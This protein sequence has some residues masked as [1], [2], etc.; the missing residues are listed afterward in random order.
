[1]SANT[2][3]DLG[4]STQQGLSISAINGVGGTPASG[5]LVGGIVDMLHANNYTN[6]V[7][8]GG[9]TSGLLSI[10]VQVSD[11]TTSG[12]FTDP[13]SGLAVFPGAF[14]SGAILIV[15]S[16]LQ[17]SG[18]PNLPGVNNAP[19]FC[20]GGVEAEGFQRTAR[21]VR[22]RALSGGSFDA[23]M[24]ALFVS[25]LKTTGSGNGF[26]YS[27]TSGTVNV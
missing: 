24:S 25:N 14:L 27:P 23:P 1:M 11:Q 19:L 17:V 13:M 18:S 7:V 15:N 16:G 3:V 20:S 6:L 26:T 12:S 4:N 10:Q 9:P 21:Y 8:V 22:A 2:L 5:E